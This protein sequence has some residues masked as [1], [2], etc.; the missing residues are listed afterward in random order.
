MAR[1]LIPVVAKNSEILV[2]SREIAKEMEVIHAKWINNIVQKYQTEIELNFGV[3][4]FKNAKP[5]D[6]VGRP[7]KYCML[8]E[9]QAYYALTRLRTGKPT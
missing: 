8:T 9:D 5:K 4:R 1:S 6:K 7:E 2:D 3:L